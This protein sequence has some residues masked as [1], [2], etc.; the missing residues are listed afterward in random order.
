[1]RCYPVDH[2]VTGD[3]VTPHPINRELDEVVSTFHTLDTW[4]FNDAVVLVAKCGLGAWGKIQTFGIANANTLTLTVTTYP[5]DV[6]FVPG[7]N[8][9]GPWFIDFTTGDCD[10]EISFGMSWWEGNDLLGDGGFWFGLKFDG[11]IIAQTGCAAYL[12]TMHHPDLLCRTPA[13][14]GTHR[15]EPIW[16]VNS[17]AIFGGNVD[18]DFFDRVV[19]VRE[20]AR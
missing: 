16:G 4:N 7:D 2:A 11:Q 20:V 10:L 9:T 14:A 6:Y 17:V 19:T 15:I 5:H 8:G 18:I 13:S 12:R 1:M 3:E